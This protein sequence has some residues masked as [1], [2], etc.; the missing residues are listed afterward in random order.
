MIEKLGGIG[1]FVG[2]VHRQAGDTGWI[3]GFF[4]FFITKVNFAQHGGLLKANV[5]NAKLE[6]AL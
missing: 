6:T 2:G 5:V 1:A 3:Q 4:F